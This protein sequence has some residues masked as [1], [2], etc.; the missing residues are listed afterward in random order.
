MIRPDD[1]IC[2]VGPPGAG[3]STLSKAFEEG[4]NAKTVSL[5]RHFY[6]SDGIYRWDE[7]RDKEA[8]KSLVH[9]LETVLA[10]QARPNVAQT[11]IVIDD[12]FFYLPRREEIIK[13][14]MRHARP[15]VALYLA[16]PASECVRRNA[17]RP[18]DRRIPKDVVKRMAK[19]I[20]YPTPSEGW[21]RIYQMVGD[22]NLTLMWDKLTDKKS[23]KLQWAEREP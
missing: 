10:F 12:I 21:R 17:A 2:L 15:P 19:D 3:K 5:D 11:P 13:L 23:D 7:Q 18:E 8:W 4:L 22:S 20:A 9:E 6:D 14:A 16:T 1:I